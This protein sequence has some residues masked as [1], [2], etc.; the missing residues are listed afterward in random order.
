MLRNWFLVF[1]EPQDL[2]IFWDWPTF[3]LGLGGREEF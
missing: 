2:K 1:E 3:P